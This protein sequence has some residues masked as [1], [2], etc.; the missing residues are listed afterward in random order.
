M[1]NLIEYSDSYPQ[2]PRIIWQHCRDESV[3]HANDPITDF[4]A[5]NA[6][7]DLFKIKEK[8]TDKTGNNGTKNVEIM[9]LLKI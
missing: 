4:N 5:A 8:I 3:L 2:T 7:N 6:T 9:V 1:Y